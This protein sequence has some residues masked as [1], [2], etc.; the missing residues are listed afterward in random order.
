[1]S[2]PGKPVIYGPDGN[3]I[4]PSAA[5]LADNRALPT[6]SDI[7]AWL[8]LYDGATGDIGRSART[9]GALVAA[10]V[11]AISPH[12]QDTTDTGFYPVRSARSIAAG[13]AGALLPITALARSNGTTFDP[14]ENNREG[15]ALV[16][17]VRATST[18]TANLTN[19]DGRG[20]LALYL[21]VTANPGGAE[22]LQVILYGVSPLPG[23]RV[24]IVAFN[25][26][27]AA[28]NGQYGFMI[29]PELT[30]ALAPAAGT[31]N[32]RGKAYIPLTWSV[33]VVHSAAGNWTYSL[34]YAL[35]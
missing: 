3:P 6:A 5:L 26:I 24:Q 33:Q 29:G 22:T 9:D 32:A 25:A 17:A 30:E 11:Q 20:K 14:S 27:P 13:N 28:A 4:F 8:M 10:G 34:G 15:T 2:Y 1:M 31:F 23:T 18:N 16:S 21:D 12:V 7:A 35:V 19:R